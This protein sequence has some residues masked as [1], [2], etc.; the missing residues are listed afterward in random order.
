MDRALA[1]GDRDVLV[2]DDAGEALGDAV[3]FYG[4]GRA[5]RVDDALSLARKERKAGEDRAG[6]ESIASTML[7][8]A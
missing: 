6:R 5:G 4:G 7:L 1:D 2:G 3:Q 8:R